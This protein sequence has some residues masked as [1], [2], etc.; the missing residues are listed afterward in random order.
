MKKRKHKAFPP[1]L[2]ACWIK[3]NSTFGKRLQPAGITPDQYSVLRWIHELDQK[4]IYQKD[5]AKLLFTDSNNIASLLNRMEQH[6]LI[7]RNPVQSDKRK[8]MVVATKLGKEKWLLCK[9]IALDVEKTL[10][11]KLSMEERT[12]IS[13]TLKQISN[14]LNDGY[15]VGPIFKQSHV[16]SLERQ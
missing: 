1:A 2:R 13:S 5:L 15:M 3:L 12:F 7:R 8:K 14:Y 6:G 11:S 4:A 10:T 9:Q 16:P